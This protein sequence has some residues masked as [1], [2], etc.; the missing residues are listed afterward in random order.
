[1]PDFQLRLPSTYVTAGALSVSLLLVAKSL[2]SSSSNDDDSYPKPLPSPRTTLLPHLSAQE[3]ADL[4]YAPD[5]LPG[6]RHVDT[7]YGSMRVYEWGPDDGAKVL[8]VHGIST[9][10]VA[11]AGVADGLVKRGK[12]VMLFGELMLRQ[13]FL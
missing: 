13:A 9:P 6:A 12:R 2:L 5:A 8:L 11:L 10:C 1:M 7:P 4:P 3:I